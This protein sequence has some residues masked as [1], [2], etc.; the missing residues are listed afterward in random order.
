MVE[1][2]RLPTALWVDAHLRQLN[3]LGQGHYIIHKGAYASG[4]VLVKVRLLS[5]FCRVL[6]QIR[7]LDGDLG[8]MNAQSDEQVAESDADAYIRRAV[9]RDPD[10]WVIEVEDRNGQ[11]PFEGQL[12]F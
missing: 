4:M 12:I 3:S 7:T 8:W 6:A 10:L 5:D 2:G 1:D 11:N 9:E